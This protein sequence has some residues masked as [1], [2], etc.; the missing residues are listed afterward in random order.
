MNKQDIVFQDAHAMVAMLQKGDLSAKELMDAHLR[1][2]D[3]VNPKVN[4]VCTMVADAA[5]KGASDADRKY[6]AGENIGALHGL[7]VLIKDLTPTRGIRTTFGSPIYE[8]HV[9]DKDGLVVSRLKGAG[10]IVVGKTNSPEFGAGSHTFNQVFGATLNPYSLDRTC[11]G[12]SGGA[13][14][15]LASGMSPIAEGSDFG[16]SLRNPGA[17]CNVVGFRTTI[18]RVPRLPQTLG[19]STMSVNGPMARSVGDVALML[20]VIAG[21]HPKVPLSLKEPGSVFANLNKRDPTGLRIAWSA[22]LG[23]RPIEP[24]VTQTLKHAR[25]RIEDMGCIVEETEPDLSGADEV[26]Q[27]IR[28]Y[29]FAYTHRE[30]YENHREKLKDTIIW[31]IEKGLSL[32]SMDIAAAE[33]KRTQIWERMAEFWER[34]DFLCMPVT[35]LPPFPSEWEYPAVINGQTMKTYVDWMWPCYVITVT[36]SP[37]ISVPAGFTSDN[38]P[39]GLQIVGPPMNDLGVLQFAALFEEADKFYK[40]KPDVIRTTLE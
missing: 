14:A 6:M 8:D 15:A 37:S 38:L 17:W 7:P 16:G 13:A 22:N 31:N 27:T 9:P 10:A 5:L 2:I 40:R 12:S 21:P 26:F 18:G 36:G 28:A 4:A 25:S 3:A 33:E 24:A 39:V 29:S 35:S 19:W 34:F 1:Q 11:G 20:S 30:H 23:G 32:S